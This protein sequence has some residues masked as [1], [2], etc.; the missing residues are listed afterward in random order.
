MSKI[1]IRCDA[2][3]YPEIGTGHLSRCIQ[4]AKGLIDKNLVKK[5]EIN[6]IVRSE[7]EFYL[8]KSILSKTSF[9]FSS[10]KNETLKPNSLSELKTIINH[11]P[12]LVI[13][14]RLK[15]N[16]KFILGLKTMNIKV[17]SFDDYGSGRLLT[18]LSICAIFDDIK[19]KKNLVKGFDYLTLKSEKSNSHVRK[20]VKKIVATFGGYDSRNLCKFF[21]LNSHFISQSVK[22]D[23]ILGN[24]NKKQLYKQRTIP[25]R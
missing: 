11:R 15:T 20:S 4:I 25:I 23:L 21:L 17:I 12:Q 14:D 16:K 9:I 3:K 22:I 5:N 13:I 1:L 19:R 24:V 18:D 10:Y 8:G 6:F 2:G 7:K